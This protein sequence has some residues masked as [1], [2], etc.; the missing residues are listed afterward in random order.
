M[1]ISKNTWRVELY[2]NGILQH[3]EPIRLT[4]E[5]IKK[6]TIDIAIMSFNNKENEN[7]N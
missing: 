1:M 6:L 5:Q 4:D 7:G 3:D 2:A